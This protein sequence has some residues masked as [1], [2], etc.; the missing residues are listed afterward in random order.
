MNNKGKETAQ[1]ILAII[2][3]IGML[4]VIGLPFPVIV[5]FAAIVYLIWRAVQRSE[6]E[7]ARRIFEFYILASE[8]L[9]DEDRR[10]FGFE[11]ARAIDHGEYVLHS[12]IDPPPLVH[13]TLGALYNY[14]GDH[15]HAAERLAV[16][17]ESETLDELHV[18]TPSSE[19]RRYVQTLRRMERDPSEAP[20]TMAAIR[21]LERVR[22]AQATE[23]LA[24]AREK[25]ARAEVPPLPAAAELTSAEETGPAHKAEE[26]QPLDTPLRSVPPPPIVELL[27][28]LY[29]EKKTA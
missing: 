19:L 12:M 21:S 22:R 23:M 4:G 25:I 18:Y 13:F 10:W 28:D 14:V 11:V 3:I 8:I 20:Q 16:V 26:D 17:V 5:F 9:R 15:E 29:E 6:G 7:D 24:S 27:R 1:R 2:V